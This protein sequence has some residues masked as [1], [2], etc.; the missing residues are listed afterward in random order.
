MTAPWAAFDEKLRH[1]F[2]HEKQ[3][4][5]I[6]RWSEPGG[7]DDYYRRKLIDVDKADEQLKGLQAH[8][9][10]L[11]QQVDAAVARHAETTKPLQAQLASAD[12][13]AEKRVAARLAVNKANA[14]LK[15]AVQALKEQIVTTE[16][17]IE[18]VRGASGARVAIENAFC[19]GGT[20]AE[21]GR[22]KILQRAIDELENGCL[23]AWRRR[24]ADGSALEAGVYDLLLQA[25]QRLVT[26]LNAI[27]QKRL[28]ELYKK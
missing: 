14:E 11:N 15:T 2:R 18:F 17:E 1:K 28:D 8:L 22:R 24:A 21:Q 12:L 25:K 3:R 7:S 4:H 16:D 10:Q 5:E 27:R 19:N 26:E 6:Q 20:E 9:Q 13:A 23:F